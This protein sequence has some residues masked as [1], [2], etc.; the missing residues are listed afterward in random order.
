MRNT[1]IEREGRKKDKEG[2][3]SKTTISP[4]V[5]THIM[6]ITTKHVLSINSSYIFSLLMIS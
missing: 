2:E 6:H 5:E 1:Y 3:L 4:Q